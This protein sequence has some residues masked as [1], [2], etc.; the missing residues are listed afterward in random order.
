MYLTAHI[1]RSDEGVVGKSGY[2][3]EHRRQ[4]DEPMQI[5]E[6]IETNTGA[7]V[8]AVKDLP[9]QNN[10][11]AYLDIVAN[12]AISDAELASA[13]RTAGDFL[14]GEPNNVP[15]KIAAG[16]VAVHFG[17]TIGIK[18]EGRHLGLYEALWDDALRI[19]CDR[20][21]PPWLTNEPLIVLAGV[22]QREDGMPRK[23]FV[24]D[25]ASKRRLIQRHGPTWA[26]KRFMLDYDTEFDYQ[27]DHGDIK[28]VI[29]EALTDLPLSAILDMG[30]CRIIQGG[31]VIAEWPNRLGRIS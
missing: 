20:P 15:F 22:Q 19:K 12:D 25:D 13:R 8:A 27:Q 18:R 7:L 24:L 21:V 14:R 31:Q 26:P 9:G 28:P 29:I 6:D 11:L 5:L 16:S 30:G 17:C 23:T 1:V 2:L 4:I 10:V 3:Y